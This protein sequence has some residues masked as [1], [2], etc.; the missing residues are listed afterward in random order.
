M[1]AFILAECCEP[2]QAVGRRKTGADCRQRRD[3]SGACSSPHLSAGGPGT[4]ERL[5][6]QCLLN[7]HSF[8]LRISCVHLRRCKHFDTD[9]TSLRY[10]VRDTNGPRGKCASGFHAF[11]PVVHVT[12]FICNVAF[13]MTVRHR[14]AI[15]P[16]MAHLM[17]VCATADHCFIFHT[18]LATPSN[19]IV[20]AVRDAYV[21]NT[22]FDANASAFFLPS[23]SACEKAREAPIPLNG[24]P[25][26]T[27]SRDS[28][29]R[30]P[31]VSSSADSGGQDSANTPVGLHVLKTQ[32]GVS[33]SPGDLMTHD[34]TLGSMDRVEVTPHDAIYAADGL[35]RTVAEGEAAASCGASLGPAWL[36]TLN[37]PA[38]PTQSGAKCRR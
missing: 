36:E 37:I 27:P 2:E 14:Y 26:P 34:P 13:D 38:C 22:F 25:S 19:Q 15:S 20:W 21:G 29:S 24:P 3:C 17:S 30:M 1:R 33:S 6:F 23:L 35:G 7:V 4:T 10:L 5:F 32:P 8:T 12:L 18:L 28:P 16:S 9:P 31:R 11:R